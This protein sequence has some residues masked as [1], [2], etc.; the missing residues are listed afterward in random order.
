MWI[1]HERIALTCTSYISQALLWFFS[2]PA[3][4]FQKYSMFQYFL[5]LAS[6]RFSS[7]SPKHPETI[8]LTGRRTKGKGN[9]LS[10]VKVLIVA[11]NS[12]EAAFLEIL[13][14]NNNI[15]QSL[16]A[17]VRIEHLDRAWNVYATIMVSFC[18]A[19]TQWKFS[20]FRR[21]TKSSK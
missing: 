3:L 10:A 6:C 17:L 20:C 16:I 14:A 9:S 13:D 18:N 8:F 7:W 1:Q 15:V 4:D 11:G 5:I 21:G 12:R 19:T 2:E